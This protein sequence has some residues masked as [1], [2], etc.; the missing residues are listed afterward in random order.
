MLL[1]ITL[2][3]A[4]FM[5]LET[6][7]DVSHD[8]RIINPMLGFVVTL[9]VSSLLVRGRGPETKPLHIVHMVLYTACLL[10]VRAMIDVIFRF[11]FNL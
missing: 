1:I 10:Y 7:L 9:L 4:A 8:N 11:F 2:V 5:A 3:F 6:Q